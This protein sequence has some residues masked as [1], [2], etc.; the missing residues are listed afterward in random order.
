M[1]DIPPPTLEPPEPEQEFTPPSIENIESFREIGASL[2]PR[3]V[4]DVADDLEYG[5]HL[6]AATEQ[7]WADGDEDL[8]MKLLDAQDQEAFKSVMMTIAQG[9]DPVSQTTPGAA[10]IHPE[11][12]YKRR[13]FAQFMSE[14]AVKDALQANGWLDITSF[15]DSQRAL[16]QE[17]NKE[18]LAMWRDDMSEA[19]KIH[20]MR[21]MTPIATDPEVLHDLRTKLMNV[22]KALKKINPKEGVFSHPTTMEAAKWLNMEGPMMGG[23]HFAEAARAMDYGAG[24]PGPDWIAEPLGIGM[25]AFDTFAQGAGNL[26]LAIIQG[27]TGLAMTAISGIMGGK[28]EASDYFNIPT[29]AIVENTGEVVHNGG[30]VNSE[31]GLHLQ[32]WHRIVTRDMDRLNAMAEARRWEESQRTPAAWLGLGVANL[33]GH[34]LGFGATAGKAWAWSGKKSVEGAAMLAGKST[35]KLT[36]MERIVS[37]YTGVAIVNGAIDG[38]AYGNHEGYAKAFMHGMVA[39]PLFMGLGAFGRR[40]ERWFQ[41][42]KSMPTKYAERISAG[43]SGVVEGTG[44][45]VLEISQ[46]TPL[47]N[48]IK[49]PSDAD[50]SEWGGIMLKNMLTLGMLKTVGAP[51]P[52]FM[53]AKMGV[54]SE[55]RTFIES[56]AKEAY[57]TEDLGKLETLVKGAEE[58]G[59]S[60]EDFLGLGKMRHEEEVSRGVAP[61]EARVAREDAEQLT[62]DVSRKQKGLDEPE[63]VKV[64]RKYVESEEAEKI[65][66]MTGVER[67][68]ELERMKAEDLAKPPEEPTKLAMQRVGER[69]ITAEGKEFEGREGAEPIKL[70]EVERELGGREPRKGILGMLA[71]EGDPVQVP[72]RTK[73]FRNEGIEGYLDTRQDLIRINPKEAT[74]LSILAHE[75]SHAMQK[76]ML[77]FDWTPKSAEALRQ[78]IDIGQEMSNP[79]F[80]RK[81]RIAE[82]FAEFWSRDLMGDAKL[83]AEFPDLYR[84]MKEW[85][86]EAG[87]EPLLAQ[88]NRLADVY[89]RWRDQGA[90][91]RAKGM[92]EPGPGRKLTEIEKAHEPG[93][94]EKLE[95]FL[96]DAVDDLAPFRRVYKKWMDLAGIDPSKVSIVYKP[97]DLLASLKMSAPNIAQGMLTAGMTRV[98]KGKRGDVKSIQEALESIKVEDLEEFWAYLMR[99][100]ELEM[101]DQGLTISV[102]RE[103]A[104]RVVDKLGQ[105]HP[106]F[107]RISHDIRDYFHALVDYV[108]EAGGLSDAQASA[109]KGAYMTYIPFHRMGI[110]QGARRTRGERI[111]EEG[112]GLQRMRGGG[113][114]PILDPLVAIQQMTVS[115]V[116]RAQKAQ[117]LRAAFSHHL[118]HEGQGGFI[119]DV[120]RDI[121]ARDVPLAEI[122]KAL[123]DMEV[124]GDTKHR[125]EHAV[126]VIK[127]IAEGNFDAITMFAQAAIPKRGS[128]IAHEVHYSEAA[129]KH[130]VGTKEAYL[131]ADGLEGAELQRSLK[132]FEGTVRDANG[133]LK[134]L[135]FDPEAF[136]LLMGVNPGTALDSSPILRT[137]IR[138]PATLVRSF[139]T[140]WNALFAVRNLARDT[141][142]NAMYTKHGGGKP[143]IGELTSIYEGIKSR[144]DVK[145]LMDAIGGG[146]MGFVGQ[147]VIGRRLKAGEGMFSAETTAWQRAWEQTGGKL[148]R[149][150]E[151]MIAESEQLLRQR[152]FQKTREQILSRGKT[153]AEREALEYEANMQALLDAKEVTI[154]FTRGTSFIRAI[155]QAWPYFGASIQG[156]RK[157]FRAVYGAEGKAA[158]KQAIVQG[159][160]HL[161][162]LSALTYLWHGNEDWYQ[163]LPEWQ[164]LNFWN[165]KLFGTDVVMRIP[166]PFEAGLVFTAPVEWLFDQLSDADQKVKAS[167]IAWE[168]AGHL[169]NNFQL[170]PTFLGVPTEHITGYNFFKG[171]AIIPEWME[172]SRMPKDQYTKYTTNTAKWLGGVFGISPAKIEN[173]L[174][175]YTA[176]AAVNFMRAIEGFKK[177]GS[178]PGSSMVGLTHKYGRAVH[179]LYQLRSDIAKAKGSDELSRRQE[180]IS[181]RVNDALKRIGELNKASD[182]GRIDV[183]EANQRAYRLAKRILDIYRRR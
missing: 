160:T 140:G 44:M 14:S 41:Q 141:Q 72:I 22:D 12:E 175:G 84:E 179:D 158:K 157:F 181:P 126:D 50:W 159:M 149:G 169:M 182:S 122:A 85:I 74:R 170:L 94:V 131:R 63:A 110:G 148:L 116:V 118:L 34:F 105:K 24:I 145:E 102:P 40:S 89:R 82:G 30:K 155:N 117:V 132:R 49:D 153:P 156:N 37:K 144:R 142:Q 70:S 28:G 35:D 176:G 69:E 137:L 88:Y 73:G 173:T 39:A 46:L 119:T 26:G 171:R 151:K 106:E 108:A 10:F 79:N 147:E 135:E 91:E 2:Q 71:R 75:W 43:M 58:M 56:S 25:V 29:N 92:F 124:P 19:A 68:A 54:V 23:Q 150:L 101:D 83:K 15:R 128:V 164:R 7:A 178:I 163:D 161:S 172:R 113:T 80:T 48:F 96:D 77:G 129:I 166:K 42:R 162:A 86:D 20:L 4:M 31:V 177:Q 90:I 125:L 134:W 133:K 6:R 183:H 99:R 95:R 109:I 112:T 93:V 18:P 152:E 76:R 65:K 52:G 9:G 21:Q 13:L 61:E 111:A 114:G 120:T 121:I 53:A 127:D 139:A 64:E 57:R 167:A 97:H 38:I 138:G 16:Y 123:Q 1:S 98:G 8:A 62:K 66:R 100:K 5:N 87:N 136:E 81:Q 27:T 11:V 60:K 168:M 103:E 32:L 104:Q 55:L 45:G 36:R 130:L 51:S 180:S 107:E 17:R 47:W 59:W 165:F 115:L 67:I 146:G 143:I 3:S 78:L 33:A 154:N 174:G